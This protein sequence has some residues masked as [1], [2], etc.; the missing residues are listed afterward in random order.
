[1]PTRMERADMTIFMTCDDGWTSEWGIKYTLDFLLQYDNKINH[2]FTLGHN[3][4][5]LA[6]KSFAEKREIFYQTITYP[7][8]NS[9]TDTVINNDNHLNKWRPP[10]HI[11]LFSNNIL[12]SPDVKEL[13]ECGVSNEISTLRIIDN[14]NNYPIRILNDEESRMGL[15]DLGYV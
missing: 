10:T 3:P 1:M 9:W 12:S 15:V 14:V 11:I 7:L 13:M 4:S 2:I 8:N 6:A 5:L